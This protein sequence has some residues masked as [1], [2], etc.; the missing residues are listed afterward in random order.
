MDNTKIFIQEH[1]AWFLLHVG[2]EHVLVQ[3][4]DILKCEADG[5]YTI[6]SLQNG[7]RHHA[8]KSLK[9]YESLLSY[10]GFLRLNRS[11]IINVQYITSIYKKETVSLA[12]GEKVHISSRFRPKVFDFIKAVS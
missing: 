8:S 2:S 11:C 12:S 6:F 1:D 7:K 4:K 9:Y 3:L 5:N 10:N